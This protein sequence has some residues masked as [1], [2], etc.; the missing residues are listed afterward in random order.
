[1]K[2]SALLKCFILLLVSSLLLPLASI[3]PAYWTS[4][5]RETRS[6]RSLAV[7]FGNPRRSRS[8]PIYV[9][10]LPPSPSRRSF[11]LVPRAFLASTDPPSFL[12]RACTHYVPSRSPLV[13][14]LFTSNWNA[15]RVPPRYRSCSRRFCARLFSRRPRG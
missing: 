15:A 14:N 13:R 5:P 3:C 2:N 6:H 10:T 4:S 9:S 8:L 11:L 1:M 12:L 7:L